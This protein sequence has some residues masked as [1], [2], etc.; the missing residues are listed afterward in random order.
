MSNDIVTPAGV[1]MDA[2]VREIR[3]W[4]NEDPLRDITA[5]RIAAALVE[6]GWVGPKSQPV[7]VR[8]TPEEEADWKAMGEKFFPTRDAAPDPGETPVDC[9][10]GFGGFHEELNRRCPANTAIYEPI[11]EESR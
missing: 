4:L 6:K 11:F 5:G 1:D 9:Q 3:G 10:C 2:L 8:P 7:F